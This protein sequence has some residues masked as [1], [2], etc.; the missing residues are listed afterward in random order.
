VWLIASNS[1][2]IVDVVIVFCLRDFYSI[3]LLNRQKINPLE[4][5][6]SGL[7]AKLVSKAVV[8]IEALIS[9]LKQSERYLVV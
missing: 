5:F 6:Q 2:S 9:L 3:G 4:L 8:K 7:L 1:A